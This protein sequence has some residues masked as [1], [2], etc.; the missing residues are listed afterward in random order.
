MQL[1][2]STHLYHP[3]VDRGFFQKQE[4]ENVLTREALNGLLEGKKIS[5]IYPKEDKGAAICTILPSGFFWLVTSFL[6]ATAVQLCMDPIAKQTSI[7]NRSWTDLI[8]D[9]AHRFREVRVTMQ[10]PCYIKKLG[11]RNV[12]D[13]YF[14]ESHKT[15][16]S[17]GVS[18]ILSSL[19]LAF[20][21]FIF[22]GNINRWKISRSDNEFNDILDIIGKRLIYVADLK[23][24]VPA[25]D[26]KFVFPY[27]SKK[28]LPLLNFLQLKKAK[29][30]YKTLFQEHLNKS[31]Y[32]EKQLAIWRLFAHFN[33]AINDPNK[34]KK[35]LET[36]ASHHVI[37]SDPFFFETLICKLQPLQQD[38]IPGFAKILQER[39]LSQ[40]T[41]N[42][43]SNETLEAIVNNISKNHR[44]S[45]LV[46]D[47]IA[48]KD[49]SDFSFSIDCQS[50]NENEDDLSG[51]FQ[52]FLKTGN[53]TIDTINECYLLLKMAK[54]DVQYSEKALFLENYLIS[55]FREF[56]EDRNLQTLLDEIKELKME[57]LKNSVD[58]YLEKVWQAPLGSPFSS[59]SF[60][61][62]CLFAQ[63]NEL[64]LVSK[65]LRNHYAEA[66]RE[67]VLSKEVDACHAL[68]QKILKQIEQF[69]KEQEPFL[70]A[71]LEA[72][73]STYLK[74]SPGILET[75]KT[76]AE[77]NGNAW[78]V[79]VIAKVYH[80]NKQLFASHLLLPFDDL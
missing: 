8:N 29:K 7:C 80:D 6:C 25:N 44:L 76:L 56:L 36:K 41:A 71:I 27:L 47:A 12:Q 61:D 74:A 9:K 3:P 30:Y 39:I 37:G 19:M 69:F 68:I 14:E 70:H 51:T 22:K 58:E 59:E 18:F 78:L 13:Y 48:N 31:R 26:I 38:E 28:E 35:I 50:E 15:I 40:E 21:A 11:E 10:E 43:L 17:I 73:I 72:K 75:L 63:K 24:E 5:R 1:S 53:L 42:R 23:T 49:L 33:D 55:R 79:A 67:L 52:H 16:I 2:S 60:N 77:K 64:A 62:H 45:D 34:R 4:N 57:R 65:L 54:K 66:L 46:E 32:S 20:F